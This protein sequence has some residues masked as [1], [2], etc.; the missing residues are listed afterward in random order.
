MRYVELNEGEEGVFID[1]RP[2]LARLPDLAESLPPGARAFATDAGHYDFGGRRCVKDL[3]PQRMRRTGA[4]DI[5]IRF[6][7]NCWKH[8][9]DLVIRYRGVSRFQTDVLGLCD[10][11]SLGDV[12]L[13]E[14]L[15][16]PGGCTHELSCRPGTLVVACRDLVA[17]WVAA[18]C[19][20]AREPS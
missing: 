1:P 17:R 19:P 15:P 14:I 20:E 8:D 3:R 11:A 2:Y 7:H 10:L 13:D 12:I 9:E 18:D 16:R 5:E 4:D 6:R